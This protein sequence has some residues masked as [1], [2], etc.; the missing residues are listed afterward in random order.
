M[1]KKMSFSVPTMRR[2][3]QAMTLALAMT[4][5]ACSSPTTT[6][7]E[8][9]AAASSYDPTIPPDEVNLGGCLD[10]S[11]SMDP[12]VVTTSLDAIT[13][14]LRDTP[15]PAAAPAGARDPVPGLNL[16]IRQVSASSFGSMEDE[17]LSVTIPGVPG[18]TEPPRAEEYATFAAHSPVWRKANELA[19]ALTEQAAES[20]S[21]ILDD[22]S[23]VRLTSAGSEIGGCITAIRDSFPAGAPVLVVVVSDLDQTGV[24]QMRGDYSN[25]RILVAHACTEAGRCDESQEG[26]S[27]VFSQLGLQ[28]A[29]FIT[30]RQL[31]GELSRRLETQ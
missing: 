16:V 20:R 21:E 28:S 25:L 5:M 18:I 13:A 29:D 11:G 19:T 8:Q 26:W 15:I 3:A 1:T 12:A 24:P 17:L 10:G 22:L 9:A 7:G 2:T 6:G 4:S 30:I 14:A 27:S 31:A 23:A